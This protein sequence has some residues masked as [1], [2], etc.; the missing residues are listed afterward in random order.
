[1]SSICQSYHRY[2]NQRRTPASIFKPGDRVYL[3]ASNIKTTRPSQK[4]SHRNLGPFIVERQVSPSAYRLRLPRSM[5]RL[6]PVFNVVKLTRAPDDPIPGRRAQP[7]P[8]PVLVGDGEE[9]VVERILDSRV[10]RGKL[11]FKVKWKGYGTEEDSWEPASD[12]HADALVWEFYCAH[13]GAPWVIAAA[14]F[15]DLSCNWRARDVMS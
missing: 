13:P 7:P 4:L 8:P 2:Y 14:S 1:M 5:N 12:V 6:H 3:D 11:Q 15:A 9:Y 10:R